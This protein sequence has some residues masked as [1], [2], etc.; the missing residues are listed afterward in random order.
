MVIGIDIGG[1][2]CAVIKGNLGKNNE[3]E[4]TGKIKIDTK[5]IDPNSALKS[6]AWD[7]RF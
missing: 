2:K 6:L 7:Y 3:I 1:T 5:T 4:I